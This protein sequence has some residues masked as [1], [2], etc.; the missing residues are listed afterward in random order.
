M[1]RKKG[2]REEMTS[3]GITP[4]TPKPVLSVVEWIGEKLMSSLLTRN[5]DINYALLK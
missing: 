1:R 3:E 2:L 5:Y 4:L